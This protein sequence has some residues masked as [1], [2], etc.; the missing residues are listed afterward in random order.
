MPTARSSCSEHPSTD[1]TNCPSVLALWRTVSYLASS[2]L[3]FSPDLLWNANISVMA[4]RRLSS[5][6]ALYRACNWNGKLVDEGAAFMKKELT[7][8]D[9]LGIGAK[10]VEQPDKAPSAMVVAAD[11]CPMDEEVEGELVTA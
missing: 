5:S 7:V 8:S 9:V 10:V 4:V 1:I 2:E 11:M 3:M 6:N